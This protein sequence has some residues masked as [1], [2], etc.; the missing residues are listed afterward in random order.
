MTQVDC[1]REYQSLHRGCR[2]T[3]Q[4]Q[5]IVLSLDEMGS[6]FK[7]KVLVYTFP[8]ITTLFF[9]IEVQQ[10]SLRSNVVMKNI[11]ISVLI[12]H[13]TFTC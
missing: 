6:Y 8:A 1:H 10:L 9:C 2:W 13:E 5:H 3:T 12:P 7:G 4:G 11:Y